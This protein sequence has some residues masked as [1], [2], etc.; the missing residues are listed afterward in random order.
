MNHSPSAC[1]LR[2][3]AWLILGLMFVLASCES[4]SPARDDSLSQVWD[5]Q[6]RAT[7]AAL[8]LQR[9]AGKATSQA[10][11]TREYLFLIGQQTRL[12]QDARATQTIFA[13]NSAGTATQQSAYST[14]T[15]IA[16][17]FTATA[18]ALSIANTATAQA[19]S[20]EQTRASA[21]ATA[22]ANAVIVE[23]TR[24]SASATAT[25]LAA[26]ALATRTSN[27]ATATVIAAAIRVEEEK[28]EWNRRLEA[29][30][31]IATFAVATLALI[32]LLVLVGFAAL[33]FIDA[34]VLRARVFRDKTGTIF[35]IGERDDQGRQTVLIP[36]RSPGAA[37]ALTPPDEK[38]ITIDAHA[39][40]DETTKRDQAISLMIAASAGKSDREELLRELTAGDQVQF[41]DEPPA[42]LVSG[43]VKSLLD[44]QWKE[45][46]DGKSN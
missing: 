34:G 9:A 45:L 46:S 31:A 11:A 30:R 29:G 12:A 3:V 43:E 32:G 7:I 41:V 28:A 5:A 37:L 22:T 16:A 38:P 13:Q 6:D 36:G 25:S 26:N 1:L 23:A 19:V 21:S 35:V 18:N 17:Q 15:G 24:A 4:A 44:G 2:V 27:S 42:Q 20:I 33:R 39:I 8:T 10:D 14:A 40:D